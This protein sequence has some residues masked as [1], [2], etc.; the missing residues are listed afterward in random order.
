V[1]TGLVAFEK[2]VG[3]GGIGDAPGGQ[4]HGDQGIEPVPTQ[5]HGGVSVVADHFP[6]IELHPAASSKGKEK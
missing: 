3:P 5:R 4:Q 6:D 1:Q 2:G